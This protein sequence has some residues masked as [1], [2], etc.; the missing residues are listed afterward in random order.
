MIKISGLV[1]ASDFVERSKEILEARAS[2]P[3]CDICQKPIK[4]NG[5]QENY[6]INNQPVHEDC[7]FSEFSKHVDE[8]P[9]T[10]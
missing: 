7:Y 10:S 8:H 5:L 4:A 1:K 9:I 2:L 6:S 3:N